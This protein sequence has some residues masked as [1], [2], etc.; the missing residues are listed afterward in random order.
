MGVGPLTTTSDQCK[1]HLS[2]RVLD[3][4]FAR[5]GLI[6]DTTSC[7]KR[8]GRNALENHSNN[9][10][11]SRNTYNT[12]RGVHIYAYTNIDGNHGFTPLNELVPWTFMRPIRAT[13]N[14]RKNMTLEETNA[15]DNLLPTLGSINLHQV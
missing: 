6:S 2:S 13:K 15:I 12:Y 14:I 8:I 10:D 11:D 9:T 4:F 5:V 3:E 1:E 7:D